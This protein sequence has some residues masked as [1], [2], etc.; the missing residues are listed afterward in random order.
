MKKIG[1]INGLRGYAILAVILHHLFWSF[2]TPVSNY[3]AISGFYLFP[4]TY[5]TNGW[6]GVKLFFI[7][8]GFVLYLP[9]ARG[10]RGMSSGRDVLS[11]YGHR[12]GRLL[13]LYYIS[14]LFTLL[15]SWD[16]TGQVDFLKD[17]LLLA[18]FTFNFTVDMW[19]PKYNIVLWSLAV[20]VW[21]C[22]AF[23]LLV[24]IARR[25]GVF[26]LFLFCAVL[27]L[28][29]RF[30]GAGN[31]YFSFGALYLDA[32]S[33]SLPGRLD[34]FVLGM[35]ICD[36]YV[37][38]DR[39]MELVPPTAGLIA[40]ILVVT[41]GCTLWDY[42]VVGLIDRSYVPLFAS[43]FHVGFFLA[44][45]SL[46]AMRSNPLKLLFESRPLQVLGM[47]SYSLYIW[48]YLAMDNI[49]GDNHTALRVGVYLVLL[50]V[51][52][53]LSYRYIEFGGKR[54][55]DLFLTGRGA[56]A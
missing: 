27:G 28:A 25:V 7:L 2:T 44:V 40:G 36:L 48:H 21:F 13:P 34:D 39:R 20:E 50:L 49:V 15:F 33:D 51:F 42:R 14:V 18:T 55:R 45:T 41:A 56:S 46:L 43:V 38:G 52:S 1:V 16:L 54:G 24:V 11:F 30:A 37:R 10:S 8:S 32:L 4:F 26:R 3:I 53:A 9:Y 12:A 23:P 22:V 19:L 31:P 29:L 5:I 35:L 6:V 47:M 17:M